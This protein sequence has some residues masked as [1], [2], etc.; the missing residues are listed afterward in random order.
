MSL[1]RGGQGIGA[2]SLEAICTFVRQKSMLCASCWHHA[3]KHGIP[4]SSSQS[5]VLPSLPGELQEQMLAC[6]FGL[7]VDS[8]RRI[9]LGNEAGSDCST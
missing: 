3:A 9:L 1:V 8:L 2:Q 6:V 4:Q 5:D 7:Q